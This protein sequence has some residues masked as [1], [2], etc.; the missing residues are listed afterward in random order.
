MR[1]ARDREIRPFVPGQAADAVGVIRLTVSRLPRTVLR[2]EI[3]PFIPEKATD[4]ELAAVYR[5]YEVCRGRLCPG[6]PLRTRQEF[7]GYLTQQSAT[8]RRYHWV[9]GDEPVAFAELAPMP[10]GGTAFAQHLYVLPGHRR[11]GIGRALVAAVID[12]GRELGLSSIQG[13]YADAGGKDFA[14][15]VGAR[16]GNTNRYSVLELPVDLAPAEAPGYELRTWVGAAPEELMESY[17][18]ARNAILDSPHDPSM[19]DSDFTAETIRDI[20]STRI[21]RGIQIRTTVAL[22]QSGRVAGYT[23]VDVSTSSPTART[24]DTAVLGGHRR[25]G[26]ARA[27]KIESLRRLMADRP[28]VTAVTTVNDVTNT[29]MLAVNEAVGFRGFA[30]FTDAIVELT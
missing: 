11:R 9:A 18:V 23:E 6:E 15:A 8:N 27:V 29:G 21:R 14:T 28:D 30:E 24:D 22:D 26:V 19:V 1:T 3:R 17:V 2:M 7:D 12:T 16:G 4:A 13:G 25:R 10:G 20:E 5:V